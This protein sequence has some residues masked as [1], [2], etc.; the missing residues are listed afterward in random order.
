MLERIVDQKKKKEQRGELLQMLESVK[1]DDDEL[2]QMT[3]LSAIQTKGIRRV[4]V[5]KAQHSKFL[6]IIE[7]NVRI[8]R[9]MMRF[10]ER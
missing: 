8:S 2:R 10:A 9:P 7:I 6:I 3:S 5:K 1:A 4:Q